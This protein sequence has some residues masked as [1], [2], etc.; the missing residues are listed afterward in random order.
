MNPYLLEELVKE[1]MA[2]LHRE[3]AQY[4]QAKNQ[5]PAVP[6]ISIAAELTYVRRPSE[7]GRGLGPGRRI[8]PTA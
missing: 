6:N 8:L 4:R 3:A 1:R 7:P 5:A 2:Q